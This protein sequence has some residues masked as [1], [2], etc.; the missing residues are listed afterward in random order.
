M[1]K[2]VVIAGSTGLVGK[3]LL[4]KVTADSFFNKINTLVRYQSITTMPEVKE[5]VSDF[6]TIHHLPKADILVI[7]LGTTRKKAGSK[8]AFRKVDYGYVTRLARLA[9]SENYEK[10]IVISSYGA[11]AASG[12]FYLK[13][14]GQM[15]DV[16]QT[17]NIPARVIIRPSLLLGKRDEFRFGESM[18][19]FVMKV[20]MPVLKG[21]MLKYKPVKDTQVADA[22]IKLAK[23]PLNGIKIIEPQWIHKNT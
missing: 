20:I 5:I 10:I 14:K 15:E 22:I 6:N 23:E 11:N 12:N 4:R 18:A 21:R 17:V 16:V 19:A 7:C 13:V 8:E 2:S 9:E 3:A 1:N